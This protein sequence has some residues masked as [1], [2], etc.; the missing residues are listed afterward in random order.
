MQVQIPPTDRS[1][2]YRK[3][4]RI[5]CRTTVLK[6]RNSWQLFTG[7]KKNW[8]Y[9]SLKYI[10]N[11]NKTYNYHVSI[12][13]CTNG[14]FECRGIYSLKI[15]YYLHHSSREEHHTALHGIQIFNIPETYTNLLPSNSTNRQKS[16]R[17]HKHI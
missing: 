15:L 6:T 13:I 16:H 17:I 10:A 3:C 1:S 5:T 12:Q 4:W 14:C 11:I 2:I 9:I 8:L 7:I